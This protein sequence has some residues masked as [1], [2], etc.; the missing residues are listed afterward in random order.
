MSAALVVLAPR[1]RAGALS[2][3]PLTS[4]P[5]AERADRVR[6]RSGA[7]ARAPAPRAGRVQQRV[8]SAH[9]IEAR[10]RTCGWGH[11]FTRARTLRARTSRARTSRLLGARKGAGIRMGRG[12]PHLRADSAMGPCMRDA[13]T[14]RQGRRRVCR[15]RQ[16][17][18]PKQQHG[19]RRKA[20]PHDSSFWF[21][22]VKN[23]KTLQEHCASTLN[24][25]SACSQLQGACRAARPERCRMPRL[26]RSSWRGCGPSPS[27]TGTVSVPTAPKRCSRCSLCVG[28]DLQLSA[29]A[30]A[31][32]CLGAACPAGCD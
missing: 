10:R 19:E 5:S 32:V 13:C 31:R 11:A 14:R 26:R 2:T 22:T 21:V 28:R 24:A 25:S 18:Q 16:A 7:G 12:R 6:A 17:E 3:E 15:P 30:P 23:L 1:T 4:A 29:S 27:R 8:T 20:D 9:A